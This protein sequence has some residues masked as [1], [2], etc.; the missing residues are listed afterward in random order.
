MEKSGKRRLKQSTLNSLVNVDKIKAEKKK[1]KES[2]EE[3]KKAPISKEGKRKRE[4]IDS[5]PAID[6]SQDLKTLVNF[7]LTKGMEP[8]DFEPI[9]YSIAEKILN[10]CGIVVKKDKDIR[11][12]RII[13]I[14]FYLKHEEYHND[15]FTHQDKDQM[16]TLHWYF[17]KMG[18]NYKCASYKGLDISFGRKSEKMYGG[19]L[20]R[21]LQ[22]VDTLTFHEGSCNLVKEI[23]TL[24]E[25]NEVK[26]FLELNKNFSKSDILRTIDY[27]DI[28]TF[29]EN[30]EANA[31]TLVQ[32]SGKKSGVW[33]PRE[34]YKSPRVGLTL[35]RDAP[36]KEYF[37]MRNYRF[38]TNPD[39]IKKCKSQIY[40]GLLGQGIKNPDTLTKITKKSAETH[41]AAYNA[42]L[43]SDS[44]NLKKFKGVALSTSDIS[45]IIGISHRIY[46]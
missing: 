43:K 46:Q 41:K 29:K 28:D 9:F 17:H 11:V 42:G 24:S 45:T 20:L 35:K 12:F 23:F 26:D 38:C 6:S 5:D 25:A 21:T 8:A 22:D 15:N 27:S 34:I 7:K 39:S 32:F 2:Y 31:I 14:E 19:I 37:L 16:E 4:D 18:K 40:L 13:E 3:E 1:A 36:E 30:E 33:T 10:G 44:K